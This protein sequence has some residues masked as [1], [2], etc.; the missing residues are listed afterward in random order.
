MLQIKKLS[1]LFLIMTANATLYPVAKKKNALLWIWLS[2]IGISV[3]GIS[4]IILLTNKVKPHEEDLK[5][6]NNISTQSF[7]HHTLERPKITKRRK[8]PTIKPF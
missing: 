2:G 8:K 5:A 3:V 7:K 4:S 6:E 1:I